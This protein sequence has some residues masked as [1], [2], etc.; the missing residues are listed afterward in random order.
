[1]DALLSEGRKRRE[2][3]HIERTPVHQLDRDNQ[4]AIDERNSLKILVDS[5]KRKAG[6]AGGRGKRSRTD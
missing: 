1:M 5:V 3:L 4:K 2:K 6:E